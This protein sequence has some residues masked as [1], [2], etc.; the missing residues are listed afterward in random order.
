MAGDA[1]N[2]CLQDEPQLFS[3]LCDIKQMIYILFVADGR[4]TYRVV[5]SEWRQCRWTMQL[6]EQNVV[7][8]GI[9]VSNVIRVS[10]SCN[11]ARGFRVVSDGF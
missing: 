4:Q 10:G 8:W 6:S 3:R 2:D 7:E 1:D 11:K 9:K 5:E